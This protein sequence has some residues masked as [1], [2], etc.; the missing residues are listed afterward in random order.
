MVIESS[1]MYGMQIASNLLLLLMGA[2]AIYYALISL[3]TRKRRW[4]AIKISALTKGHKLSQ[5]VARLLLIQEGSPHMEERKQLLVGCGTEWDANLYET[6]R[7]IS[8]LVLAVVCSLGYLAFQQPSLTLFVNPVYVIAGS[9]IILILLL[10]DRKL[11]SQIKESRSQRIVKEIYLISQQLLY[12]SG[13]Q[14]NLHAK[15]N[16]CLPQTRT[17][18]ASFQLLLNEWYQEPKAAIRSFKSR[19]GSDEAYSFGETLQALRLDE[20]ENYYELLQQRI[21]DY[22]EKIELNRESRKEAVSYVLFVLAGLPILNTFR[23]F[24]YPWI[25]EGQQLFNSING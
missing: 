24:M 15:L 6:I 10:F 12:Y 3:P 20:Q 21:V 9:L 7:R 11:L 1:Q 14:M 19:L 16:R 17:L 5:A 18:R 25:V 2:L 23:V 8:V 4:R 22:K 13:S